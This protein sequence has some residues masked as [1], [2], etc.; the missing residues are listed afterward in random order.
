MIRRRISIF[1]FTIR[2]NDAT[3]APKPKPPM[4]ALKTILIIVVALVGLLLI[5]GL[6]G[7][8]T[9]EVKRSVVV[10]AKPETVY[11]YISSLRETHQWGPWIDMEKEVKGDWTGDDG[12][13]GS[14][15]SWQ[16]DTLGSGSQTIVAMEENKK[17][18][19][20]LKFI[21]PWESTSKVDMVLTPETDSTT[22]VDWIMVG[23]N[24]GFM[25]RL[26][27]RFMDLDNMIGPDFERGLAKLKSRVEEKQ[28]AA[29][30]D[31]KS[32]NFRGYT[33]ETVEMPAK[34][35]IGKRNPKLKW[36]EFEKF[37]GTNF[38]GAYGAVGA[39]GL[40]PTCCPSG[41]FF[42]WNETDQTADVMAGV[43]IEGGDDNTK[44]KGWE[45]YTV[46]ASKMLHIKFY[47]AYDKSMEAHMAMD[48]MIKANG[49]THYGNVVEEYITDPSQE[50]D[51][52]KWLT[53]IY[54]M[55][56]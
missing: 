38:G 11:P 4:R 2:W 17:V 36:T 43:P 39:A 10:N 24:E 22:R 13:I 1:F 34:T 46:P 26:M 42:A 15:M 49:L 18:S 48:D 20:D 47:G 31:F 40:K 55:V 30:A 51:T 5:L 19:T 6:T 3:F 41:I 33:I 9:S 16:G 50:P 21:E 44:V 8:K 25:P 32:K 52:A 45:T 14:S 28:M 27:A 7:P 37:Y 35:Y 29:D 12:T 54:Y 56:R 53:N 23:Q